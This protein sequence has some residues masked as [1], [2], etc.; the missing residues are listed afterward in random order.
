MLRLSLLPGD[1]LDL[2][3]QNDDV[4]QTHDLDRGE[5]L[6]RLWLRTSLVT[7]DEEEGCIHYCCAVQH[8]GHENVVARAI[9]ERHVPHQPVIASLRAWNHIRRSTAKRSVA[10]RLLD[11]RVVALVN[12]RIRVTELDGD[13]AFLLLFEAD[14][15]NTTH[16]LH[17]R[18]LSMC[19]VADRANVHGRLSA[20]D[21]RTQGGELRYIQ[22]RQ[23]LHG[24]TILRHGSHCRKS[25]CRTTG[26]TYGVCA[27]CVLLEHCTNL[28]NP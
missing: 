27:T 16:A 1:E 24:Q 19:H 12:L 2:V 18:R 25:R 4:L 13:V 7:S 28:P 20:D 5:V 26:A 8:R 11:L 6:R 9:H 15:V 23:V 17:D 21:L 14:G 22:G 3:L 10:A